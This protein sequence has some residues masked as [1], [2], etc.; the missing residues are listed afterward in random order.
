MRFT[1]KTDPNTTGGKDV[2]RWMTTGKISD[3]SKKERNPI[4]PCGFWIHV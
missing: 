4:G 3:E 2:S 1:G